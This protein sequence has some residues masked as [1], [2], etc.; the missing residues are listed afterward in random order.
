MLLSTNTNNSSGQYDIHPPGI[1]WKINQLQRTSIN[2]RNLSCLSIKKETECAVH[3]RNEPGQFFKALPRGPH[4]W[5]SCRIPVWKSGKNCQ[6]VLHNVF[7][8]VYDR[9]HKFPTVSDY[10]NFMVALFLFE[11]KSAVKLVAIFKCSRMFYRTDGFFFF[12]LSIKDVIVLH[13]RTKVCLPNIDRRQ[14]QHS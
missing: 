2:D 4:V 5:K 1:F 9:A 3:V 6:G 13:T 12:K 8:G 11:S 10:G 14:I 7:W